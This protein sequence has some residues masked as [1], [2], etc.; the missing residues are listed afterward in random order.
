MSRNRLRLLGGAAVAALAI[1]ASAGAASA[2]VEVNPGTAVQGSEATFG[3][4]VPNE[5][6]NASTTKVQVF[7]PPTQPL[8]SVLVQPHT[9]WTSTVTRAKLA[10]P[11]TTDDGKVTEAVSTVTWTADSPATAIKPGQF[12]EFVVSAG[13]L[14][15][16]PSMQF[17]ALQTYSDG[18]I[19][20]WI[21]NGETA[22]NPAP[23]LTLTPAV[24]EGAAATTTTAPATTTKPSAS[25]GSSSTAAVVLAVMAL[26]VAL[27]AAALG[28][29]AVRRPTPSARSESVESRRT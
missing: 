24:A 18:S 26:I 27:I 9:G 12:D 20:R 29:V 21:Q 5:K 23:T 8:G 2:H 28:F 17:K 3:F 7:L 4:Q 13:P 10:T 14:P 11:I 19:V 6:D 15:K 25:T 22:E 1:L 16:A